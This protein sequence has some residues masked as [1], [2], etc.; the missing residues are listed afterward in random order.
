MALQMS[1]SPPCR[2]SCRHFRLQRQLNAVSSSDHWHPLSATESETSGLLEIPQY[3]SKHDLEKQGIP[4][5]SPHASTAS[6]GI[7]R[8]N[9][10]EDLNE[11][12][13]VEAIG[14]QL[15]QTSHDE[16]IL[17]ALLCE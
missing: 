14:Q 2:R 3:A 8:L 7:L 9:R 1:F 5:H 6:S 10:P 11:V 4:V 17:R 16:R 12:W 15:W 13:A